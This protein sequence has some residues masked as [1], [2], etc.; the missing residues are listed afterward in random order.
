MSIWKSMAGMVKVSLTCAD[1][2]AALMEISSQGIVI[3]HAFR[4]EEDITTFFSIRRQDY[5][6]LKSITDRRGYDLRLL[7][8]GGLYWTAKGFLKRPVLLIGLAVLLYL[9]A[10]IPTR[11]F[12]IRIDGNTQI[13]TRMILETCEQCGISFGASRSAVRSEKV[14]NALLEAIPQLQ[15]A[16]INTSGCVATIT[17]KE[18]SSGMNQT[19]PGG[20]SSI[21]ASR[22]GI[23]RE[24][25]VTKGNALCKVGQAVKEG[26]VLVSG[27]TDCGITTK[28]IRA[29]AE[30]YALTQRE[31]EVFT[32]M[33]FD[34]KVLASRQE[35]KYSL[36]IGKKRINLY[37]GSGISD[38]TCDKI[39]SETVL[40]LPGG[41]ALP[42]ILVTEAWTYYDCQEEALEEADSAKT[43]QDFTER[44][45]FGQ[46][47]AGQILSRGEQLKSDGG[48]YTMHGKYA[49]LEMIGRVRDEEIITPDGEQN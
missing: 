36:I 25:T 47:V 10:W 40:T 21:V 16:G 18:R 48:F 30:V 7:R 12:F 1:P 8:R 19:D 41:F 35:K 4:S 45:L 34:K 39:C 9:T 2:A 33:N 43:L 27:Y 44:Y 28:A 23:I 38:T 5:R 11:V 15:W 13:P 14:K 17:V 37:K 32:P 24:C 26:E 31:I 22:D 46:M 42:V 6:R 49:C 3:Y 29:E 20:V